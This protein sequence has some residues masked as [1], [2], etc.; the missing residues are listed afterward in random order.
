MS[1]RSRLVKSNMLMMLPAFSS[2][3]PLPR[4]PS[5]QLSS[6]KRRIEDW[7]VM[8]MVNIVLFRV[9]RNDDQRLARAVAAAASDAVGA[10]VTP[11]APGPS[12]VVVGG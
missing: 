3:E 7:S 2:V 12:S 4:R 1:A 11:Q 9:R 8:G 10:V 5:L 6:M